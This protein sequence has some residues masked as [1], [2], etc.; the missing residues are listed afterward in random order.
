MTGPELH[1]GNGN[2]RAA[3]RVEGKER[4]QRVGDHLEDFNSGKNT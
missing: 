3:C 2:L 4:D 1:V